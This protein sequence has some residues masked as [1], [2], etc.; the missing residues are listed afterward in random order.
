MR[1]LGEDL[2]RGD[3]RGDSFSLGKQFYVGF[4]WIFDLILRFCS[5]VFPDLP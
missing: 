3:I 2:E 4:F 5:Y 1:F